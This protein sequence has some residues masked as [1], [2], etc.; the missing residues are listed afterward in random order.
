VSRM[1]MCVLPVFMSMALR[2]K[3]DL[4]VLLLRRKALPLSRRRIEHAHLAG[5]HASASNPTILRRGSR[6]TIPVLLPAAREQLRCRH[7]VRHDALV[8]RRRL[9]EAGRRAVRRWVGCRR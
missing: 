5:R 2:P 8:H 9:P 6:R 3:S 1:R 4:C 7:R